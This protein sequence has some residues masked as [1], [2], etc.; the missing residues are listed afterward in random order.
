MDISP[1]YVDP[2]NRYESKIDRELYRTSVKLYDAG[3]FEESFRTF[4]N[5]VNRE[6]AEK[7]EVEKNHWRLPH[8]SLMVDISIKPD[9]ML[10]VTA[11]FIKLP[12]KRLAP[13]LRRVLDINTNVL[14]LP[15]IKLDDDGLFFN[16]SCPMALAEPFKI[17]GIIFEIC[18]NGDSYDDEFIEEFGAVALSE[19]QVEYLPAE[20]VDRAWE[21]Y[22]SVLNEA[23]EYDRYF[24]SKRWHGLSLDVMG[25]ALMKIDYS[26]AP[27]GYLRSR[28]EKAISI[29]WSQ[30]PVE[31]MAARLRKD[32]EEFR[33]L[34]KEK[35]AKDFYRT[36]FFMHARRTM[37]MDGCKKN[38]AQ[39]YDWAGQDRQHHSDMGLV[40]NYYYAC[41]D[42][43]YKYFVPS[44]LEQE[45]TTT[46]AAC[47]NKPWA[48]AAELAWGSFQ[49]IMDPAYA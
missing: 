13:V 2:V 36:T 16:Y 17:Y 32:V 3:N 10:D 6:M 1:G 48:E 24:S 42:L 47:S 45:M 26:L 31:D 39:R 7:Y 23:L 12:E 4:M 8:G 49:K 20:Q 5:Y 38:M 28:L 14:T 21:L 11:P 33:Q 43:M 41:Y 29:L 15:M 22:H 46:L 27:Q 19:K 34:E 35:F 18:I 25:Q 30:N 44:N 37:E 9:G 40:L